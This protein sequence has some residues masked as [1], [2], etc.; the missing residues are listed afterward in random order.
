MRQKVDDYLQLQRWDDFS[1]LEH[2]TWAFLFERQRKALVNRAVPE[3]LAGVDQLGIA[4]EKIPRFEEITEILKAKTGWEIVAVPGLVPDDVFFYLLAERKFP[5][6]CFI[7]RPDQIDYLQEP[8]IFHD[9]FGHVPLLVHPVFADYMEAY[10]RQ[11]MAALGTGSL[12]YLARLYWYTVEFGLIQTVEG[13]RIYGSG[14]VSSYGESIYCLED[15]HPHRVVFDRERIM[16][17]NYKIDA[18]QEV[19][20]VIHSFKE[21]MDATVGDFMDLYELLKPLNDFMP[22]DKLTQDKI[23]QHNQ[24][25]GGVQGS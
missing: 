10:G 5:S 24:L 21:L 23:V 1:S 11:G 22:T 20:F 17:S 4:G 25:L 18:Y 12:H 14:I 9:I 16:R 2:E 13:L 3:F 19:Y 8:D 15:P 7:R 6:T